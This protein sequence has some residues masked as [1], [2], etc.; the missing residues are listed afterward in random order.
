MLK[1]L[2][3]RIK[4]LLQRVKLFDKRRDRNGQITLQ[5]EWLC[6]KSHTENLENLRGTD[7]FYK[8]R[9]CEALKK[10]SHKKT[11]RFSCKFIIDRFTDLAH[12]ADSGT[13]DGGKLKG[14]W[15]IITQLHNGSGCPTAYIV[16]QRV[17]LD[18]GELSD[19]F[20]NLFINTRYNGKEVRLYTH[21][22]EIGKLVNLS[23]TGNQHGFE[24]KLDGKKYSFSGDYTDKSSPINLQ[25]GIYVNEEMY[26]GIG[27]DKA[28]ELDL[29]LKIRFKDLKF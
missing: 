11:N 25:F 8:A 26:S 21:K 24:Y 19:K 28:A 13:Y 4:T 7:N 14:G 5:N 23:F 9:K 17:R 15:C 18:N 2:L 6:F 22:I 12:E 10:F 1:S 20:I 16:A 3:T 29:G 27:L